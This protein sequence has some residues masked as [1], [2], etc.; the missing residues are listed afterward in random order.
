M[1]THYQNREIDEKFNDIKSQLNRIETQT[2]K[3]NGSVANLKMWRAYTTGALAVIIFLIA[4][5]VI[6]VISSVIQNG[7]HI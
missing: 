2:V 4:S 5:I 3:T 7:N 1:E 6:P